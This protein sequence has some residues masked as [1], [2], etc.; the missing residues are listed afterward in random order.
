VSWRF[1]AGTL[2]GSSLGV[3]SGQATGLTYG[4][5]FASVVVLGIFYVRA[6]RE[7]ANQTRGG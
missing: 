5:F 4:I 3:V 6:R 2:F 7:H 1:Y